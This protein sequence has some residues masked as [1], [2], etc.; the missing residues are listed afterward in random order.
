MSRRNWKR[1]QPT[2]L[3]EA[4]KGCKDFA[5]ER[6]HLSVER[7][8]ERMCLEDHW[9]LYKWIAN[10]RMPLVCLPAYEHACGVN[11][12]TRWL[13]ASAGQLLV[14]IPTGRA[15][16][17]ADQTELHSGFVDAMKLI[18]SFYAGQ[19]TQA[20]T[21]EAITQHM[22]HMAWHHGN[23]AAHANPELEF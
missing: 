11:F 5:L 4:L 6:H 23:V 15:I 7:I 1:F 14:N 17:S 12:G 3:R 18:A 10:G 16:T 22:Q 8:A 2:S 20:E 13:A 21:L 9:A 19:A